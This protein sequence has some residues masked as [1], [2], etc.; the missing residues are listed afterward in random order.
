MARGLLLALGRGV[1]VAA[2]AASHRPP[3]LRRQAVDLLRRQD[4]ALLEERALVGGQRLRAARRLPGVRGRLAGGELLDLLADADAAP[5]VAAHR[6]EVG[7]DVEVLVVERA[8]RVRVEGE[9]E[10]ALPV[11]RGARLRQL[12]VAVAAPRD[13][14]SDVGG[15]PT[16]ARLNHTSATIGEP[17]TSTCVRSPLLNFT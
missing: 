1:A 4:A 15:V 5:V 12:V 16:V 14:E 9:L 7:V 2:V 11:Q 8:R 6:A 17:S 3:D 10:V 13:P